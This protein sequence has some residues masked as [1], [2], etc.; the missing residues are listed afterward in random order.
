M[1]SLGGHHHALPRPRAKQALSTSIPQA[2]RRAASYQCH[3]SS[4]GGLLASPGRPP[5]SRAPGG[6]HAPPPVLEC[7][8]TG[9]IVRTCITRGWHRSSRGAR[10]RCLAQVPEQSR[11][12]SYPTSQF[13]SSTMR[14]QL[15]NQ[16]HYVHVSPP[17]LQPDTA[18]DPTPELCV[19]SA[20]I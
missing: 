7:L 12:A 10:G 11:S 3:S 8:R 18:T 15:A 4:A 14:A 6:Q 17:L 5:H 13:L 9:R 20:D 1:P 19:L 16:S 2:L